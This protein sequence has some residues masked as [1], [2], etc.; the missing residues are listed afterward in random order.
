VE[1]WRYFSI[2]VTAGALLGLIFGPETKGYMLLRKSVDLY[3]TTLRNEQGGSTLQ[4]LPCSQEP[5]TGAYPDIV[6]SN[7]QLRF[8]FLFLLVFCFYIKSRGS[9]VGIATACGLGDRGFGVRI[10]VGSIIFTSPCRPDRPCGPP[11]LLFSGYR[12]LFPRDK[13]TG[14]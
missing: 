1:E 12:W 3:G 13:T 6:E 4:A 7:Q 10:P 8:L 5:T 9:A 14:T 2:Q 11:S